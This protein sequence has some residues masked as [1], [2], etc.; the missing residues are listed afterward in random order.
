MKLHELKLGRTDAIKKMTEIA[1]LVSDEKREMTDEELASYDNLRSEVTNFDAKIERAEELENL[2]RSIAADV[3]VDKKEQKMDKKI[4]N[5]A[6]AI[7]QAANGKLEGAALEAHQRALDSGVHT[8]SPNAI[9][10]PSEE[11]NERG[12]NITNGAGL[13]HK[14]VTSDLDIIVPEPVYRKL[15]VRVLEGLNGTL[16]LPMQKHN[17]ATFVGEGITVITNPNVPSAVV[18]QPKRIGLTQ[19][20]S[21]ELLNSANSKLFSQ[22]ISDMVKGIDSGIS[23][24]VIETAITDASTKVTTAVTLTGKTLT[25]LEETIE[26][27]GGRFVTTKKIFGGLKHT[28]INASSGGRTLINGKFEEGEVYDGYEMYGSSFTPA[29]GIVFGAFNHCTVGM[30]D[31]IEIIVDVYTGAKLGTVEITVNR[32]ADVALVNADAFASYTDASVA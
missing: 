28:A 18:I 25:E 3:V 27:D 17:V 23:K 8:A 4:F 31:G 7:R 6:E 16:G 24:K 15:G 13:I 5:I 29:K 19:S 14:D 21:K 30:W 22:I 1:E 26:A 20:F 10:I 32:L 2:N 9:L 12:L 11:M